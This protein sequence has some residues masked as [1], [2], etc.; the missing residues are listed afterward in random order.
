MRQSSGSPHHRNAENDREKKK[1]KKK[2]L[3]LPPKTRIRIPKKKK[4]M[5]N[6][7]VDGGDGNDDHRDG[8]DN[9]GDVRD[10]KK[11]FWSF[12]FSFFFFLFPMAFSDEGGAC[13]G[14]HMGLRFQK[15]SGRKGF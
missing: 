3:P 6:G 4:V 11:R 2:K 13:D 5:K 12:S 9:G 14:V 10:E 7:D 8:G 1:K 15:L